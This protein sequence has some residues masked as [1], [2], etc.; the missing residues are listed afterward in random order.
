MTTR[1][2]G[3]GAAEW[4]ENRLSKGERVERLR[5]LLVEGDDGE[6]AITV[7]LIHEG[8]GRETT[9]IDRAG[10][11]AEALA[12][13]DR[14]AYGLHLFGL[15]LADSRFLLSRVQDKGLDAPVIFMAGPAD[16][17]GAETLISAGAA[18]YFVKS[19]LTPDRLG[20]IFRHALARHRSERLRQAVEAANLEKTFL[21]NVVSVLPTAILVCRGGR[22]SSVNDRFAKLFGF[23]PEPDQPVAGWLSRLGLSSGDVATLTTWKPPA[24]PAEFEVEETS[25]PWRRILEFRLNLLKEPERIHLWF[26][27]DVTRRKTAEERIRSIHM[28]EAVVN[29]FL[30]SILAQEGRPLVERLENTLDQLLDIPWFGFQKRGAIFLA[31]GNAGDLRLAV[32][33]G[34]SAPL[35]FACDRVTPGRCLCGIAAAGKRLVFADS[36]DD[37]HEVI[38]DGIQ[39]HGHYCVPLLTQGHLQG[40]LVLYLPPGA[41]R[42]SE[43]ESLLTAI[44][45]TL[46]G[47]I[48]RELANKRLRESEERFRLVTQSAGDAIVAADGRG[49]ITFWNRAAEKIFGYVEGE[50]LGRAL[51]LL[52]PERYRPAHEAGLARAARHGLSRKTGVTLELMGLHRNGHEFPLELTMSTWTLEGV[53]NFAAVLRDITERKKAEEAQRAK[54]IAEAA[55]RAK[56]TFLANMSHEIRT[57]LNAIL[58]MGELLLDAPLTAEHKQFLETSNQAGEALLALINDVLDLSKIEAGQMSLEWVNYDL[59][60]LLNATVGILTLKAREKDLPVILEVGEGVPRRVSGDPGRLRQVLINLLNNAIKFTETGSVTLAVDTSAG[61]RL[62]FNVIDTGIGIAGEKLEAIFQPFTQADASM[63]RRFGGTGLGLSICR[64][65]VAMMGGEIRVESRLGAGSR[66]YFTARLPVVRPGAEPPPAPKPPAPSLKKDRR[67][68]DRRRGD[69]R[70]GDRRK[71]NRRR[72]ERRLTARRRELPAILLADDS[73]E[74]RL[75]IQGFLKKFPCR[76]EVVEN[77]LQA[78]EKQATGFFDV[79]IM[80]IQMPEMDGYEATRRIRQREKNRNQRRAVIIALTAHALK[81]DQE[82]SLAA[83]CDFHLNKPVRRKVLLEILERV[84]NGKSP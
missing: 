11:V 67:N 78:L 20:K 14:A 10:S 12:A 33:R 8:M 42:D 37:R 31:E 80:D 35:L 84:F 44:A 76:L 19:R 6:A 55:N 39:P 29:A 32:H 71:G 79:I 49:T 43:R 58:G 15:P 45:E 53:R 5:V 77:G 64:R 28:R 48:E 17:K 47:V 13:L 22:L 60:E 59:I 30:K 26:I 72:A 74:N 56:S 81:E 50:V 1:L 27:D 7:G 18:A 9:D 23:T 24:G 21:E 36:V 54:A 52:M 40:V 57:P 83:G 46:G 69:Q 2:G 51:T 34:L 41:E 61:E 68:R 4:R 70:R 62:Q 63:T 25:G 65:I 16:E 75:V 3:R 82:K 38:Y 66:F 73:E